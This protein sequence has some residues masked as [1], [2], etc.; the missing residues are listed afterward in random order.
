MA[1]G[2]SDTA[3][4]SEPPPDHAKRSLR[5]WWLMSGGGVLFIAI[6]LASLPG[7]RSKSNSVE[8][9]PLLNASNAPDKSRPTVS[10]NAA[11]PDAT[12]PPKPANAAV[13]PQPAVSTGIVI[14]AA[15]PPAAPAAPVAVRP[16]AAPTDAMLLDRPV[17]AANGTLAVSSLTSVDIYK[18]DVLL[19]SVPTSLQFSAGPL[20]LEYRHGSLRRMVTHVIKSNE[21][22]RAVVNFD[23]NVRINCK[24][25]AQVF[26]D[27]RG[28]DRKDLG[29][30]PLGTIDVAIG[31]VL[32][33]ENPQF[34]AKQYRVSGNETAIQVVFP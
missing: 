4:G 14:A 23:I 21:T 17:M 15:R 31:S 2:A 5:S 26:M 12:L 7:F 10:S 27:V 30:T 24:P 20:T 18:D 29:Q 32:T 34:P 6:L 8:A 22:T 3:P 19:G 1:E 25:W 9:S 13:A 28:M 11:Q 33:F 16:A